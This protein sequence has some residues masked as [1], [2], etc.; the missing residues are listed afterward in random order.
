MQVAILLLFILFDILIMAGLRRAAF[1][2][3]LMFTRRLSLSSFSLIME[4]SSSRWLMILVM[5]DLSLVRRQPDL[6]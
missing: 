6:L 1:S 5:V 3:S 4:P 2:V